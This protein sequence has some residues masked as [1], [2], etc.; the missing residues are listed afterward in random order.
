[1]RNLDQTERPLLGR[2]AD[3]S[4]GTWRTPSNL[5]SILIIK[6]HSSRN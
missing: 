1:M 5:R 4:P 2:F 6:Q 3:S